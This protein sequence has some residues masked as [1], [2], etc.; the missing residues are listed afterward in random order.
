MA[1]KR[2]IIEG[3]WSGYHSGQ[4]R[5]AHR[6]VYKASRKKLREWAEKTHGIRYTDGTMLYLSVRDCKPRERVREINGYVSLIE[7][8]AYFGVDSVQ[9]VIDGQKLARESRVGS[10]LSKVVPN[11]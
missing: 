3:T 4:E 10:V 5:V 2:F 8:C 7:D 1:S 9:G 6:T 11:P